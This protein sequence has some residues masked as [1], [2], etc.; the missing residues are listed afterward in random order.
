MGLHVAQMTS[1]AGMRACFDAITTNA[2]K[3]MHL[4]S[5]GLEPGCDASFVLL[6]ASDVVDAIRVRATRLQV[7]K[8]GRLIS[9]TAPST[10][11]LHI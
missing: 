5:Y 9:E 4:P 7:Y 10:P 1:Q 3:I 6:Q 2:A 8:R 11:V